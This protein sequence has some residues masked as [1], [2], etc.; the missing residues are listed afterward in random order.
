MDLPVKS[1]RVDNALTWDSGV[2]LIRCERTGMLKETA[3]LF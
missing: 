2:S 3:Y 1:V